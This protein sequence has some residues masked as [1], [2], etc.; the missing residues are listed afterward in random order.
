MTK[1]T[2]TTAEAPTNTGSLTNPARF[3]W[4]MDCPTRGRF[5]T[6]VANTRR[7]CRC[8][9]SWTTAEVLNRIWLPV[10]EHVIRNIEWGSALESNYCRG[11][12][13]A[14]PK[15]DHLTERAKRMAARGIFTQ[16]MFDFAIG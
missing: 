7:V 14:L 8:P 9:D 12:I 4:R 6:D 2:Y 5:W 10:I 13:S 16:T 1:H 3:N 15:S 11:L